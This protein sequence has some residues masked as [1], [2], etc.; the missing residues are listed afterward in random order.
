MQDLLDKIKES[1]QAVLPISIIVV[2]LHFTLAPMPLWTL[3][4]FLCGS[5]L[6]IV[7]MGVFTMGADMAMMPIGEAVGSALTRSRKVWLIVIASFILGVVVTVAEPDL[8][9]LTK[10]VPSVPD[11]V[12]V[13]AVAFGVGLFLV[14]A[15]LRILFQ[16]P[17]SVMFITAYIIVFAVASIAPA[18]F[19]PV[20]FDTGGVT[21]GPITVPFILALGVGVSAVRGSRNA[22]EDSFGLCA[23]CSIGPVLAVLILGVFFH[24]DG[25][26]Y[27]FEAPET[28]DS[29][30]HVLVL[31]GAGLRQFFP[32]VAYILMPIVLIFIIF[33]IVHLRLA[34][35]QLIR[36]LMGVIYTLVGLTIFLTGVNI[37]FMPAGTYMG[38]HL[39]EL[40]YSW[41]LI[42]LAAVLGFFVVFAEPATHVLN[43]QVEDLTNG[44]I[45]RRMMMAGVSMGVSVAFILCVIRV[46]TGISI[47]YF[48]L[49]GYL[50]AL[51]MIYFTPK[52]FTA[53][54]F[55]SGGVAA[56]TMTAAFLLPFVVGICEAVGGNIMTDAF[57]VVGMVATL[58]LV[59]L[60]IIGIIYNVKL[61]RSTRATRAMEE[62][63][64]K[65]ALAIQ[66]QALLD[67]GVTL[68]ELEP[69]PL[70]APFEDNSSETMESDAGKED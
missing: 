45:S 28:A 29:F 43:K 33:Q 21:T 20:S 39:A 14:L 69:K 44:A 50:L 13:G 34:R 49:P 18:D 19:L 37:G 68:E 56:G 1:L 32:E 11:M 52:I 63:L 47:W 2:L 40:S 51:G 36:I 17:L 48:L 30:R 24:G 57:G 55:D 62:A 67:A 54:A 42:P 15:L 41:I 46:L 38:A 22:E 7:G 6:L 8:Q 5:L 10:Q 16:F 53:I 3:V 27:A 12:L 23:L 59:T 9:I 31:Y 64:V 58:P 25:A 70:Q 4:L 61:K 35:T 26:D 60:Q 66:T 65:E